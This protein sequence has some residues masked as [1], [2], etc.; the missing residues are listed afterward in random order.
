MPEL[1]DNVIKDLSEKVQLTL[2]DEFSIGKCHGC[3]KNLIVP[4]TV[5]GK[6]KVPQWKFCSPSCI[7]KT[8]CLTK[9][10]TWTE[11][12]SKKKKD[13]AT[14]PEESSKK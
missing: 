2:N 5:T 13:E 6:E 12:T 10:K 4:F 14:N 7:R 8:L 9:S 3:G 11:K 1:I